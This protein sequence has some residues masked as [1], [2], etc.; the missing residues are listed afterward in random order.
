MIIRGITKNTT[1]YKIYFE[2]GRLLK[3]TFKEDYFQGSSIW[4]DYWGIN[5]SD[6]EAGEISGEKLI[7][8]YEVPAIIK[9]HV[10]RVLSEA[11]SG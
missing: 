5:D 6:I 4:A 10:E 3:L 9:S 11:G 1:G 2:N 8:Y 7:N